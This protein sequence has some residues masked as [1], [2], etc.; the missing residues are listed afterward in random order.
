MPKLAKTSKSDGNDLWSD[1][2]LEPDEKPPYGHQGLFNFGLTSPAPAAPPDPGGNDPSGDGQGSVADSSYK[3]CDQT[4]IM[5]GKKYRGRTFE[6]AFTDKQYRQWYKA[7]YNAGKNSLSSDQN[8]FAW[9][10]EAR[11]NAK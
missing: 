4:R 11:D 1:S 10:C 8:S 9:Y 7:R 2:L 3:S 6:V 5:F